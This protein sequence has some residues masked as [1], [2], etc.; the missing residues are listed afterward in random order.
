MV[1]QQ[2]SHFFSGFKCFESEFPVGVS[3][4]TSIAPALLHNNY[5]ETLNNN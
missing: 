5:L 2:S 3:V 1:V 4:L